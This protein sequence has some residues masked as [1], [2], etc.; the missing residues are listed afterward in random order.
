MPKILF[1]SLNLSK[2]IEAGQVK[3]VTLRNGEEALFLKIA[4][5]EKKE[6]KTFDNPDGTSRTYTHTVSC[7]PKRE[8]Q[9]EGVN[10]FIADLETYEQAP[11]AQPTPEDVAAAP[12]AGYGD[13]PF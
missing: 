3:K 1:G 8:E 9:V 10:Y 13:L 12:A 2:A 5:M 4:V 6:P 7:A 11:A